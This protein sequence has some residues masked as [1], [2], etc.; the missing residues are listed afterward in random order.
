MSEEGRDLQCGAPWIANSNFTMVHGTDIYEYCI[1][2]FNN[3][4]VTFGGVTK[5]RDSPTCGCWPS[6]FTP[7]LFKDPRQCGAQCGGKNEPNTSNS[8]YGTVTS[9]R[10][11]MVTMWGLQAL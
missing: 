8:S 11:D 4:P 2:G 7:S 1:P 5:F 9:M 3:Q 6:K 10:F